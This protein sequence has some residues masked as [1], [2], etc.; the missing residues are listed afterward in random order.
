MALPMCSLLICRMIPPF[1]KCY[2]RCGNIEGSDGARATALM[3]TTFSGPSPSPL[4]SLQ[5]PSTR[6]LLSPLPGT[7]CAHRTPWHHPFKW[8][9]PQGRLEL[10]PASPGQM[11]DKAR[12]HLREGWGTGYQL[13]P[14]TTFLRLRKTRLLALVSFWAKTWDRNIHCIVTLSGILSPGLKKKKVMG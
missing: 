12:H 9:F 7:H 6:H 11:R 13:L 5:S 8:L 4:K 1:V 14:L 10:T 2:L 3:S